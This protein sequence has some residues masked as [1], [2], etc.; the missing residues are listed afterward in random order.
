[1]AICHGAAAPYYKFE[2]I[3]RTPYNIKL[4]FRYIFPILKQIIFMEDLMCGKE[5]KYITKEESNF[6]EDGQYARS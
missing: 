1:M 4:T 2:Y 6:H 3:L 5:L